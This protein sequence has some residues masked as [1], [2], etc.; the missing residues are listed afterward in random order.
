MATSVGNNVSLT[1][2]VYGVSYGAVEN[3]VANIVT[4]SGEVMTYD[5]SASIDGD[6]SIPASIDHTAIHIATTDEWNN[7]TS[8]ITSDGHL[9]IYSDYVTVDN[10]DGTYSYIPALKIG[11]GSHYLYELQF[12]TTGSQEITE[13]VNNSTI[14]V[15][16]ADKTKWNTADATLDE[17]IDNTEVH[18]TAAE[19]ARWDASVAP[20]Y[21]KD[22]AN[23]TGAVVENLVNEN[24]ANGD[25][26]H[27]EGSYTSATGGNAH[28]EGL[29]SSASGD[30]SHAQGVG[31]SATH[32]A[33]HV[34]GE[35][36]ALDDSENESNLRGNY[37]E[38]VGNGSSTSRAN[39]RT[40][41]WYGNESIAGALTIGMGGEEEATLTPNHLNRLIN[42]TMVTKE[43][44]LN[45][46]GY[47]EVQLGVTND[48]G[49]STVVKIIGQIQP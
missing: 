17:H 2:S 28:A 27:A 21:I 48:D 12:V 16:A 49:T 15:T 34:F 45:L 6:I 35:Y 33:Q 11:D 7:G 38:I 1:G 31:T 9:Y 14:H 47:Q 20:Q 29:F 36:N 40:L 44:I 26:S 43:F 30:N 42:N 39:A 23:G 22:S 46:L 18:I 41:D 25:Y 13:H 10:G 24:I 19:R 5:T 37:V 32:K 8:F 3:D 4:V